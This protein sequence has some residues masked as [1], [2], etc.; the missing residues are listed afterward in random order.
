MFF[1][2]MPG[3]V[4]TTGPAS[5]MS[6]ETSSGAL[7]QPPRV[8]GAGRAAADDQDSGGHAEASWPTG[9]ASAAARVRAVRTPSATAVTVG[10]QAV[11]VGT[12]LLPPT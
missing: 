1:T 11:A 12:T 6:T 9:A 5:T 3:G 7:E 10:L 8:G 2:F 4:V